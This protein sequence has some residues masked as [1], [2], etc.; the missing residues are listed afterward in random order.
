MTIDNS[1]FLLSKRKLYLF[2]V[3]FVISVIT[4]IRVFG[5]DRDYFSYQRFYEKVSVGVDS[6]RFE[7]GFELVAGIFK[8]LAGTDSFVLFL[9]VIAFASLYLKLS[10]LLNIRHYPLLVLIYAMLILPLH[11]MM[12][13][14]VSLAIAVMYWVLY[15]STHS[16]ISF[17]KKILLIGVG[18]SFHFSAIILIPFVL[19]PY[20]FWNRSYIFVISLSIVPGMLINYGMD[21]INHF[22]PFVEYYISQ[23]ESEEAPNINPFS[24]RN[25]IFLFILLVGLI[26]FKYIS[27]HVLPWFY[28]S[29]LGVALWYSFMWLP[30]FAHRFLEITLFSYLV[31]VPTLPKE[32][33][34]ISLTLLF[35]LAVYFLARS[36]FISPFFS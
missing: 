31:W 9:F 23:V 33:R 35:I 22:V 5:F 29:V 18:I 20:I 32:S 17:F 13:I 19:F 25:L 14:R 4:A 34:A 30:V 2:I 10:V 12:Q 36:L 6:S 8:L 16:D 21:I 11:E 7:P 3:A 1:L 24:S 15:K 26:N 28:V 27:K